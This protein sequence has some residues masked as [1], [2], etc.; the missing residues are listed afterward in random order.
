M[1]LAVNRWIAAPLAALAL[2]A[3]ALAAFPAVASAHPMNTS[4]VLLDVGSDDVTGEVKLPLDRLAVA[5]ERELT[6]A[7]AAGPLRAQLE[8]Y[9]RAHIHP[10]G[11]DG[12]DW[13][14][15]VSAGRIARI[16]GVDHLVLSLTLTPPSG[17]VTDFTLGY[18][19]II[20]Q[21]VTHKAIATIRSQW[22]KRT[23]TALG[24]FDWHTTAL[25]V[26]GDG[27]SWLTAI[28]A[29]TGLGLQHVGESADHLLFLLM[30]LVPAPL[31]ARG[32]RWRR[33]DDVRGSVIRV[34]HVVTAFAIGHSITLALATVGL[35][36]LPSR[37][38]ES[39]IALSILVSAVHAL[40]PLLPGGEALI[41]V[42]FGLVHGLAFAT[43]LGELGLTGGAL[44][45]S[46]VGFNL[47][48]ELTQLLVV[49]LV[50]PS[51]YLLSRTATYVPVRVSV[52][53]VGIVLSGAWFL[54]R[55][56]LIG[57]G[58]FA[59]VS[60]TLVGH[61][62]VVAAALALLAGVAHY[63]PRAYSSAERDSN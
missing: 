40:R 50:M 41:A 61:S 22:N 57:T 21:L 14:V 1:R 54:E 10:T 5:L 15:A 49:A 48:I 4:A 25:H 13:A 2:A 59:P 34:V 62:L 19:V 18:D 37:L 51:L 39:L 26:D 8:R 27:G 44:V 33:R 38:V 17:E 56:G 3:L 45:S 9:T 43:L 36:E 52:A 58:P 31:V 23:P 30:L 16:D 53:A 24:I 42:G 20:E 32:G 47:G 60:A 28:T 29:N 11:D 46:L 7:A 6:P 12:K 55:T 35:I 63:L